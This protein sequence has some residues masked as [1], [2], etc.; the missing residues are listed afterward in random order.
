MRKMMSHSANCSLC[1]VPLIEIDAYGE[2]LRGCLSCNRWRVVTTSEAF[3]TGEWR[4]LPEEDIAA[5]RGL[6]TS[7]PWRVSK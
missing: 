5:L 1:S 4:Q 6:G 3:A 2:R 7:Q